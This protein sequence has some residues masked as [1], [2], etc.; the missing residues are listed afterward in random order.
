MISNG[1][2]SLVAEAL[3][4]VGRRKAFLFSLLSCCA[5]GCRGL[6][7]TSGVVVKLLDSS[8]SGGVR[9][10]RIMLYLSYCSG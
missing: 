9:P 10:P 6:C 1:W 4:A 3:S 8:L 5:K 2:S 7:F